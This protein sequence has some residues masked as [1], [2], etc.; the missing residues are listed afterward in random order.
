MRVRNPKTA[1]FQF[2]PMFAKFE[3]I[4]MIASVFKGFSKAVATAYIRVLRL[5][6]KISLS[7]SQSAQHIPRLLCGKHSFA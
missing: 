2:F 7:S 3:R 6:S 1:T 5:Y 4:G